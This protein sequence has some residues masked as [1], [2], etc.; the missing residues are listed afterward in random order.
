MIIDEPLKVKIVAEIVYSLNCCSSG[1]DGW[2]HQDD[3]K[4]AKEAIKQRIKE[5]C[6]K[7]RIDELGAFKNNGADGRSYAQ[8]RITALEST[9]QESK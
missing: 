2:V 3:Q 4:K 6:T 9:L 7:A 1:C 5:E 8:N